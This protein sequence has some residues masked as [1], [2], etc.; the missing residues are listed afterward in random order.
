MRRLRIGWGCD[1][2]AAAAEY[3]TGRQTDE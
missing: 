2:I 1:T 3:G